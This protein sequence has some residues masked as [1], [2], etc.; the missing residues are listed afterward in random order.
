[1]MRHT[2]STAFGGMDPSVLGN[3]MTDL[4]ITMKAKFAKGSQL[5]KDEAGG[6]RRNPYF[7]NQPPLTDTYTRMLEKKLRETDRQFMQQAAH[8]VEGVRQVE[9]STGR[10]EF[11]RN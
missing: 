5:R 1:M 11:S 8:L 3:T 10:V 2:N 7:K 6:S 9:Q 4:N